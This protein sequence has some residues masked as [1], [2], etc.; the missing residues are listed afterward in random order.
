MLAENVDSKQVNA[1][2]NWS[3]KECYIL[4]NLL[5]NSRGENPWCLVLSYSN[6]GIE[7][8]AA[9]NVPVSYC[10]KGGLYQERHS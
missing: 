3:D 5:N 8:S 7:D 9:Y 2:D 1:E 6:Q 4:K 10:S